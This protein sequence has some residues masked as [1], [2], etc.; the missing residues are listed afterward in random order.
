MTQ[1]GIYTIDPDDGMGSLEVRCDMTT[2]G[3][4]WTVFQ[5]RYDG[6]QGFFQGWEKYKAGFGNLVGEFWFGLD[7]IHRLTNSGQNVLRIDL[8]NFNNRAFYAKYESFSVAGESEQYRLT[9]GAFSRNFMITYYEVLMK[10]I[11]M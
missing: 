2:D 4:G 9:V 8:M 10:H 3:G 11:V 5:R 1:D 7:K 6:S